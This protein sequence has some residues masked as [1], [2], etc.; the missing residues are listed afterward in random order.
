M[1]QKKNSNFTYKRINS[2]SYNTYAKDFP[3]KGNGG[4]TADQTQNS[5]WSWKGKD[6]QQG[7]K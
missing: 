7:V 4:A 2:K 1:T 6:H 5:I 3:L